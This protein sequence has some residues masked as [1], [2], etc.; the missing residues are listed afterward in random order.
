MEL[1]NKVLTGILIMF[2]VLDVFSLYGGNKMELIN[3][4]LIGTLITFAVL[5]VLLIG[6]LLRRWRN[7]DRNH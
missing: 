7:G 3:K 5:D 1:T 4:A 6:S 2:A